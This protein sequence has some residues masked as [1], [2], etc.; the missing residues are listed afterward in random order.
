MELV[1]CVYICVCVCVCACV[2]VSVRTRCMR[3]CAYVRSACWES[4]VR[5]PAVNEAPNPATRGA[6]ERERARVAERRR[7]KYGKRDMARGGKPRE[8]QGHD[9]QSLHQQC[10][11]SHVC[12]SRHQS[13]RGEGNQPRH[14]PPADYADPGAPEGH[15]R[16]CGRFLCV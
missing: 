16:A 5:I 12:R 2:R 7:D 3:V 10:G 9:I 4:I 1:L 8:E 15:L 11:Q 14:S 13:A 6:K